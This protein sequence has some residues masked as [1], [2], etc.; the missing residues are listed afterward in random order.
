MYR[1]PRKDKQ[2][3][4]KGRFDKLTLDLHLSHGQSLSHVF[5]FANGKNAATGTAT[6]IYTRNTPPS[7]PLLALTTCPIRKTGHRSCTACGNNTSPDTDLPGLP[8]PSSC[9][10]PGRCRNKP[11]GT[12]LQHRLAGPTYMAFFGSSDP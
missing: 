11:M 5:V 12:P 3:K 6:A 8:W 4:T 10:Y 2:T 9:R 1:H 7:P